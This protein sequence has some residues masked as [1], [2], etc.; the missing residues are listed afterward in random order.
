MVC[1]T[2]LH[3]Q[4][5]KNK[6]VNQIDFSW[7]V[8]YDSL[9]LQAP[10]RDSFLDDQHHR[11]VFQSSSDIKTRSVTCWNCCTLGHHQVW[12]NLS[13]TFERFHL[14]F[15]KRLHSEWNPWHGEENSILLG[16]RYQSYH[17]LQIPWAICQAH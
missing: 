14:H 4:S 7:L 2:H 10:S 8:N 6:R 5:A 12:G 11:Q 3:E 9:Q 1:S 13:T 15:R 17:C 16:F